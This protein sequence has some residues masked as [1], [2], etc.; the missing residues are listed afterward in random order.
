MPDIPTIAES[1][2]PGFN[3]TNW[4]AFVAPGGTPENILERW[5]QEL[6]KALNS[7]DVHAELI[8]IGLTPKPGTRQEPK[9]YIA[10]E[11]ATSDKVHNDPTIK[12]DKPS[13]TKT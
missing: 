13:S 5:N 9:D 4:Y 6:V 12:I 11:S 2:F 8:K 10:S 3:A 1:G 7:P